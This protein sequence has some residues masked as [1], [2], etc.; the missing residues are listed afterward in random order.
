VL[1][2]AGDAGGGAVIVGAGG[3]ACVGGS[4]ALV[5]AK[6]CVPQL[7][8]KFSP[9]AAGVPHFGHNVALRVGVAH[10]ESPFAVLPG[11]ERG[12]KMLLSRNENK[13]NEFLCQKPERQRGQLTQLG[14][15][16]L[17]LLDMFAVIVC[18]V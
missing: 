11:I 14:S 16:P 5:G 13:V 1:D 9:G 7:R 18:E 8:Q 10:F 2:T 15:S 3:A 12:G 6:S 17:G 4:G